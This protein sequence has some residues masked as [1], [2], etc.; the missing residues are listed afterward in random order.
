MEII[1]L[2]NPDNDAIII[3]PLIIEN[4]TSNKKSVRFDRSITE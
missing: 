4:Q 3:S 1:D 2:I